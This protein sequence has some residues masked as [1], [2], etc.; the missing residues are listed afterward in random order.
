MTKQYFFLLII[1]SLIHINCEAQQNNL[2]FDFAGGEGRLIPHHPELE[3]FAGPVSLFNA[4]IGLKTLGQKEW[5]RV[6]NYPEIGLGLSHNYLTSKSLGNPTAIYS[7]MNLPLLPSTKFKI[8]LGINLG[9]AWGI[10]PYSEQN[11]E[12]IAIGSKCSAY[13]SLNINASF[14]INENFAFLLSSGGYHYSNGNTN[15]PNKGLNMLGVEAGIRY[16]LPKSVTEI[17]TE[18]ITPI[19]K[20]SSVMIFGAWGTKKEATHSPR[21]SAGSLSAGY[22]KTL[23]HKSRLSAGVDL[24]YDEGTLFYTQKENKLKNE[25]AS[26]I[27]GG[28]ELTFS[29]LSIVTQV[30]VY[31]KNPD[32]RDPFYYERLGLRYIIAN[33]IIPSLSLKA[34]K[35]K[36]D[37]IECGLGFV[38]WKS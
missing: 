38:L 8:N 30:G 33:R 25:L 10:N 19:E 2:F 36:V 20:N 26:G 4:K 17:N 16:S 31:I 21:Y 22:Y 6:Y 11:Q 23:S 7:F 9:F 29:K 3:H 12:N 13:A 28:H 15:K 34:H 37:F 5:Q 1:I 35:F 24:F 27:F 14:R 32:A 18:P